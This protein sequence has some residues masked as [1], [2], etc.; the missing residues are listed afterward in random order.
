[1]QPLTGHQV[2][3]VD[4]DS[5]TTKAGKR[6]ASRRVVEN[7]LDSICSRL[8]KEFG[9]TTGGRLLLTGRSAFLG[10]LGNYFVQTSSTSR[11]KRSRGPGVGRP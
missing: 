2:K 1:V 5:P 10:C 9:R 6:Q 3:P 7:D 8:S 11:R 4:V